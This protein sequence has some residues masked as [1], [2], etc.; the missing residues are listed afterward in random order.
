M[1]DRLLIVG[2]SSAIAEAA[3]RIW[4]A[5][6]ARF[7][8]AG[9]SL[10]RLEAV[11]SR[12]ETA[13]A[14]AALPL[15]C[16]VA[17]PGGMA[18]LVAQ[19]VDRLGALDAVLVAHGSLTDQVLAQHDPAYLAREITV[20]LTSTAIVVEA[21]AGYFERSGHGT[22]AVLGSVAGDRGK[23]RNYAYGMTKAALDAQMAGLR[24]RF[25]GTRVRAVLVKPGPV[26]TPMTASHVKNRLFSSAARVGRD[27]VHA[28]E[29]GRGVAYSPGWWRW[30]MAVLRSLPDSVFV[31]TDL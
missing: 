11:A 5:R 4:A 25:A 14:R 16:N 30:V 21:A 20:N 27:V 3:C 24:N 23:R 31:R 26:D 28:V 10:E 19:A 2:A 6:G 13:G 29:S 7:V 8:L 15:V 22:I 1:M 17:D 9:R 12:L 18:G